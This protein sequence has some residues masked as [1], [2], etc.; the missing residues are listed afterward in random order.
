MWLTVHGVLS[1]VS[2]WWM[3]ARRYRTRSTSPPGARHFVSGSLGLVRFR[4]MVTVGHSSEG[5]YLAV[6]LLFRLFFPPLLI[7]RASLLR[8]P[9]RKELWFFT[10]DSIE[11]EGN[12]GPWNCDFA[13]T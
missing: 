13:E 6:M 3:L 10:Y 1:V 12:D 4:S 8:H 5:L 2:G 7:P 11:I 9:Q